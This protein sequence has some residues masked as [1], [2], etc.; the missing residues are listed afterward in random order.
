MALLKQVQL[1]LVRKRQGM[2]GDRNQLPALCIL[3]RARA[4]DP[5][6]RKEAPMVLEPRARLGVG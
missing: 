3:E 5:I 2:A 1:A 6:Q 4:L